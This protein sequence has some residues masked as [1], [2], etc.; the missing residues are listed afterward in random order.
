MRKKIYLL[1][2]FGLIILFSSLRSY[3]IG[4]DLKDHYYKAFV[5]Y[6]D[7]SF[8]FFLSHSPYDKGYIFFYHFIYYF[9]KNPQVMIAIHSVIVFSIVGSQTQEI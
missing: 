8:D 9:T 6:S 3:M 5:Y 1:S 7:K 4:I 2:V